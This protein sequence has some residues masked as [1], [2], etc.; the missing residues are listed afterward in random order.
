MP[1]HGGHVGAPSAVPHLR[2]RRLLRRLEEQAR[3]EAFPLEPSSDRDLA[4][5]R[6][7]LELVLHR[8]DRD[9]DRMT[10][11]AA[12]AGAAP[13]PSAWSPLQSPLFRSLW[14]ATIVSNVGSWMQDVGAGW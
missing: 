2:A 10:G 8:R 13:A 7:V 3:H 5:A 4:G 1:R 9:G 6:R 12:P 14:I 11:E